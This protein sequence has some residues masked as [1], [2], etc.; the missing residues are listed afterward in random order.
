[1]LSEGRPGVD[2]RYSLKDGK[3]MDASG[4]TRDSFST[5][6]LSVPQAYF[7]SSSP[8]INTNGVVWLASLS[9]TLDESTSRPD[10]V[11]DLSLQFGVLTK[12][13]RI[14]VEINLRSP[15][16]LHGKK[17][18]ERIVWAFKNVLNKSVTWLFHDFDS[19]SNQG[20]AAKR[21]FKKRYITD[22]SL[23][24]QSMPIAKHHPVNLECSPQQRV[25][26]RIRVPD[27]KPRSSDSDDSFE[28]WAL[29]AYEWLSLVA[30]ESP[31]I[32]SEDAIDPFLSRYQVP[33]GNSEEK[34]DTVTLTWTGFIPATWVRQLYVNLSR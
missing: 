1:M 4:R 21:C 29:E 18:F 28:D 11:G 23:D 32:C 2:D 26:Q 33:D 6:W 30:M 12:Q 15:S 31:R 9:E 24:A 22:C 10:L 8:K 17:G 27:L 14:A 7:V 34:F 25:T 13:C 20:L 5:V 16:M 19:T 3:L